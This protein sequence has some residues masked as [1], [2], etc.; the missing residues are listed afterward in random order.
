M[1][2]MIRPRFALLALLPLFCLMALGGCAP[3]TGDSTGNTS[4]TTGETTSNKTAADAAP[5]T[6]VANAGGAEEAPAASSLIAQKARRV[7]SAL[8][9]AGVK[10]APN[11]T[12]QLYYP[13]DPDT[14]NLINSSDN[15]SSAFQRL[16]YESLAEREMG[17]PQ[18]WRPM[19]AE[20]WTF[21]PKTLEYDIKLR[22]GVKWHPITFPDSGKTVENEEFTARD[23]K[24]TFDCILNEFTEAASLRSY[25]TDPEATGDDKLKVD[26]KVVDKY[27][28]KVRWKKP[29]FMADEFTLGMAV[30][31]RHVY[32][33]D[34]A[35]EPISF[36]FRSKEFADG[37]NNH[38]ANNKM[39][40]TGPMIFH[41][42]D[43][44]KKTELLRFDKYWGEPFYFS[45]IVYDYIS[46][47]QTAKQR[48]LQNE[49]DFGGIADKDQYLQAKKHENVTSGKVVP[50]E[51]PTTSYRY[52]GW[53]VK[54][55]FFSDKKV[56]MALSHAV[57]VDTFVKEIYYDLAKRQT[58]PF[59][60]GGAFADPS[61]KPIAFD[62]DKAKA[63]LEEAGWK[64]TNE[65]GTLDKKIDGR[66]V[67]FSFEL[68]IYSDA[69]SY[70]TMAQ[71]LQENFRKLGIDV[72]VS[73]TAWNLML[74]R[75]RK[76]E[77]DAT[78]LGW[79]AD[80]KSDP[81]QIWH[82]SQA[83]VVE[84]SNAIGYQNEEVDKLI[85]ELRVTMD[86]KRQVEIYHQIHRLLHD[87]QP[88]TFLFSDKATALMDS[89]IENWKPYPMLRPH[90]DNREW[91]S[92][93]PRKSL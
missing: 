76:K 71:I 30:M 93:Q 27:R 75:L 35:G 37:F 55:P 32:G 73:Q 48:L 61:V 24:F 21:D 60:E 19:L 64:D 52:I 9:M 56:R 43:K 77:F 36:D 12:L 92:A 80:W 28:I 8:T 74:Q 84:S 44:G 46:N 11:D 67:E 42:W 41:K 53:N 65:N 18:K 2:S 6:P 89:R 68:M 31:P 20:S 59:V 7:N 47:P 57:P 49:L 81:F 23:V 5:S 39:C 17:D 58:G 38:W 69:P 15:V 40:G 54:R 29:Y 4:A 63:L 90:N 70:N 78:I 34:A 25:Y 51:Y 22:K 88:Y 62:L 13:D 50:R 26:V 72:R 16:V 66:D 33:N 1:V 14:L 3:A 86:E 45:R 79:V 87:D 82:G 83:D 91:Y 10:P 85:D